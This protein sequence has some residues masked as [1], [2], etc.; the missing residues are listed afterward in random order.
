[1]DREGPLSGDESRDPYQVAL[2]AQSEDSLALFR[3]EQSRVVVV[4]T[5]NY[6]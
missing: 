1:M 6:L 5:R 4:S 2:R 3:L